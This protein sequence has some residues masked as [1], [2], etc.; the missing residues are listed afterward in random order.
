MHAV[1]GPLAR[2]VRASRTP[3][4]GAGGAGGRPAPYS[5]ESGPRPT[6]SCCTGRRELGS[7]GSSRPVAEQVAAAPDG[8]AVQIVSAG[9]LART[10]DT[11]F[12]DPDLLDCDL[13]AIEDIQHLVPRTAD[14]A[15]DLIDR[16]AA[17]RRA[18]VVT[19][20][21]GP[22]G[23]GHL[24]RRLTSRLAAGLVVQLE[25]LSAASRRLILADAAS[26]KNVRLAA[27]ALD[28]LAEQATGGGVRAT[29]GLLQNLAQVAKAFPGPL[30][31]A[32]VQQALAETGL[33]TST[34]CDVPTIVKRVAA[35]FGVSEKDMLGASRLRGVLKPRQVA[36]YL[37]RELTGLS[38]PRLGAAFGGRDHTTVLHSC[39]K[40]ESEMASNLAL[41]KQVGDV[42]AGLV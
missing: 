40:V 12:A 5:P 26:T 37:A 24:P 8:F 2:G 30:T 9:D 13:L 34:G 11:S 39:R 31:R 6:R 41:A 21:T 20:S 18:T 22:A 10:P 16:R 38:L 7:R 14:A 15:A 1:C 42:R 35:A 32:D 17:R 25:P 23:L 28:W 3:R 19:A 27:E 29:L 4:C 33:P 36:M